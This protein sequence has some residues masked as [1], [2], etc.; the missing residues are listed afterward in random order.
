MAHQIAVFAENKPG[1]IGRI[2]GVLAEA[3]VNIRAITI[4]SSGEYGVIKFLVDKP[5]AAQKALSEAGITARPKEIIAVLMEDRPGGLH[6]IA[7]VLERKNINI[8]DAYGFVIEDK[9]M[10]V[11]VIE[12]ESILEAERIFQEAGLR[13]LRDEEIYAL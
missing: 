10:A 12:V 9:K 8:E 5:D 11:L 3:G 7:Q 1:R 6:K 4:A 2:T 13:T